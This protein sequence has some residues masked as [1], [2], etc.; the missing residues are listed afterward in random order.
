MKEKLN[1][2]IVAESEA[3]RELIALL[4]EQSNLAMKDDFIGLDAIVTK[5]DSC[6]KKIA[7]LEMNRRAITNGEDMSKVVAKFQDEELN[8][9]YR[10]IKLL[11][12]EAMVQKDFN[13]DFIKQGL[14]FSNRML[15]IINPDRG[16]KTY[17]SN[18]K[19]KR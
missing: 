6:N 8:N 7:E 13:M 10:Q 2:I 4:D 17:N 12:Q 14:N 5:I 18:G 1:N 11:V 3:L 15:S 16:I 9:N 19:M